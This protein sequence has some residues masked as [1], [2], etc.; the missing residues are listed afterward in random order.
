MANLQVIL[1]SWLSYWL[2]SSISFG[3]ELRMAQAFL[4][5]RYS[6]YHPTNQLYQ[7]RNGKTIKLTITKKKANTIYAKC[8]KC[9]HN[10]SILPNVSKRLK[11]IK[12]K[13]KLI[14]KI[15]LEFLPHNAKLVQCLSQACSTK[16]AKYHHTTNTTDNLR[17]QVFDIKDVDE[18]LMQSPLIWMPNTYAWY[19]SDRDTFWDQRLYVPVLHWICT[20]LVSNLLVQIRTGSR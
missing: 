9:K 13:T 20:H 14:N 11:H 12:L 15:S 2:S 7:W 5:A 17:S 1:V 16:M 10:S 4:E 18:T 3:K 8:T 6:Y 19:T